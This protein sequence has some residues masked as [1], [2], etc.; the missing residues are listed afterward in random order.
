[1]AESETGLKWWLRY[2]VVP[3]VGSGGI[4]ALIVAFLNRPAAPPNPQNPVSANAEYNPIVE[5]TV[6]VGDLIWTTNDNG[7]AILW[8]E[9][10]AYCEGLNRNSVTGWRLPTINELRRLYEKRELAEFSIR[11]PFRL[12]GSYIW[13][14]DRNGDRASSYY[15]WAGG[16]EIGDSSEVGTNRVLCV[17]SN[18]S[19]TPTP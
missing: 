6:V 9:A 10:N 19:R 12:T 4:V 2:V 16:A 17:R 11:S 14:S 3:L 8:E 1:M 15:F 7:K 18:G 13:G 5:S